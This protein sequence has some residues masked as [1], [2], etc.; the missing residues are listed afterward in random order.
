MPTLSE[1]ESHVFL[2]IGCRSHELPWH[3]KGQTALCSALEN[4]RLAVYTQV[5]RNLNHMA[6]VIASLPR[7]MA[8]GGETIKS[9]VIHHFAPNGKIKQLIILTA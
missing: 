4:P 8:G 9:P 7:E 6:V 5:P 1:P 3:W 2:Y